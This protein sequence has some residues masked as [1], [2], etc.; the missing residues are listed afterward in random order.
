MKIYNKSLLLRHH[1]KPFCTRPKGPLIIPSSISPTDA[2]QNMSWLNDFKCF[3]KYW[4][5]GGQLISYLFWRHALQMRTN[6][7]I[8]SSSIIQI[9]SKT[10]GPRSVVNTNLW[11]FEE[12]YKWLNLHAT[13]KSLY[14]WVTLIN[15]STEFKKKDQLNVEYQS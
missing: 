2:Y 5:H 14:N 15:I 3:R 13:I 7:S 1:F 12:Y 6:W 9:R 11:K 8:F 10:K 4:G